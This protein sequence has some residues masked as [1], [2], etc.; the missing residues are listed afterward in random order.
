M[1]NDSISGDNLPWYSSAPE[2]SCYINVFSLFSC[3][4]HVT[5]SL[6]AQP[7]VKGTPLGSWIRND[8]LAFGTLMNELL[9]LL[10]SVF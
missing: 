4:S 8:V 6:S 7:K 9:K 5:K 1:L 2:V 10:I 3:Y